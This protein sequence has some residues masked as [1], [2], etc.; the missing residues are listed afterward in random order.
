MRVL[1]VLFTIT[2]TLANAG[3][4]SV[5]NSKLEQTINAV[6]SAESPTDQ[7]RSAQHLAELTKG[8]APS[9]VYDSTISDITSLLDMPEDAVRGWVAAALGHLGRRAKVA[10][11]KLLA[12]LPEADCL[13][14]DLTS[15]ASIRPA[16]KRMGIEPPPAPTY[17]DCHKAK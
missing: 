16:L 7:I 11:P 5:L 12:L 4:T 2:P 17:S 3:T 9:S 6:R 10:A 15:A 13:Q 14:G 1:A 8:V